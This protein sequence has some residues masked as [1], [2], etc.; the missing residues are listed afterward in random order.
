MKQ[1]SK[2]KFLKAAGE[3]LLKKG[4]R[5][6]EKRTADEENENPGE[7][8]LPTD[9]KEG[10][11][12]F[13]KNGEVLEKETKPPQRFSEKTILSTME[14]AGKYVENEDA[15][16]AMKEHGIGTVAT[17][18]AIIEKLISTKY[19]ERKG[20]KLVPTEKGMKLIAIFPVSE[21]KS[22]E[23]TGQWEYKLGLIENNKLDAD[24]FMN[25]MIAFTK[26]ICKKVKAVKGNKSKLY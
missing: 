2:E 12:A 19:I 4:W 24:K 13:I 5:D 20:K 26:D 8:I 23:L 18:A 14:T 3:C 21:V 25:E 6:A 7:C 10:T 22:P 15:R 9:L 17:R 11:D 16:E 1:K